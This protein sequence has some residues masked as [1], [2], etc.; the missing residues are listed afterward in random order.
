MADRKK[1][2][3]PVQ[4]RFADVDILGHV[5]N[6]NLQHYFD[7]GKSDWFAKVLDAEEFWQG[8]GIITAATQTSY[9]EQTR[10]GDYVVVETSV[11]K[12]GTKSF[13]LLQRIVAPGSGQVKA[14][15]HSVMVAYD[16]NAQ[17]SIE[18]PSHWRKAMED[19]MGP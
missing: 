14:E 2:V 5:N 8:E 7:I 15:S 17:T 13:T 6:V 19:F 16:F 11:E 12:I 18:I 4:K 1:T 9:L 10:F 3:T